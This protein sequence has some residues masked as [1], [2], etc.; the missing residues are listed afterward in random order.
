MDTYHAETSVL[1]S[2]LLEGPLFKELKINEKYFNYEEHRKI[3][4]AM[5]QASKE[6]RKIDLVI[7]TMALGD[8]ISEIGGV[9]YLSKLAESVQIGRAHV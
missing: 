1:G 8:K 9:A 7:V 5:K 6:E 2:I 3:F 4:L